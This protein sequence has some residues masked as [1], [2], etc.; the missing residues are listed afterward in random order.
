MVML[1]KSSKDSLNFI[2][3]FITESD[4]YKNCIRLKKKMSSN[5]EIC[6]LT[7]KVKL[8]QKKYVRSGYDDA[9]KKELDSTLEILENIP[10]YVIYNQN[11]EIV[12]SMISTVNDEVNA[13]FF[14]KFNK[15]IKF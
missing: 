13:Y 7:N 4:E 14:D 6:D 15:S 1:S 10:I 11:L 2:I 5:R 12:N 9:I 8:L 3:N